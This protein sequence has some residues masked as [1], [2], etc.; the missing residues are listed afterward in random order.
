[1]RQSIG[2]FCKTVFS[3]SATL[4]RMPLSPFCSQLSSVLVAMEPWTGA[5]RDFAVKAFYKNGDNFVTA[6]GEFRREFGNHR[7]R[8]ILSAHTTNL[9]SKLRGYWFYTKEEKW[10][11]K[12]STY[13]GEHCGSERGQ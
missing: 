13:T 6:Q 7:N 11:C 12:N 8:A 10:S 5:E 1:V 4:E 9:G 2:R 3:G